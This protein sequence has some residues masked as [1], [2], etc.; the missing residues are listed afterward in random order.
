M[1]THQYF[2]ITYDIS[3]L[4]DDEREQLFANAQSL[5]QSGK[6]ISAGWADEGGDGD[7]HS[8]IDDSD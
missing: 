8:N 4:S 5:F 7:F 1:N 2:T 6:A 3:K